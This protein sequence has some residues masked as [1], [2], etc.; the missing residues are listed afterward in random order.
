MKNEP[1]KLTAPTFQIQTIMDLRS[2]TEK[3][4]DGVGMGVFSD[5]S[6]YLTARGLARM[7]GIDHAEIV[8]MS[9]D[10]GAEQFRPR[11][12][13]I[14][15]TLA[16]QGYDKNTI[17]I[18]VEADGVK[19]SAFP[20]EVCMAMLEY[21]AFDAGP[22]R[23]EHALK[24]YRLLARSS[25][26]VFVYTQVGYDPHNNIP[27]AWKQFQDRV[28]LVYNKAPHGYF[29]VFKEVADIIICLIQQNCQVGPEFVPDGSVGSCWG[30]YWTENNLSE[31]HGERVQYEHEYPEDFPQAASNPQPAWAYPDAAL[32]A[33]RKWM[34]EIYLLEKF[35]N[36][37]NNKSKQ[38]MFPPS[39]AELAI[40]AVQIQALQLPKKAGKL[41][42]PVSKDFPAA[43]KTLTTATGKPTES[44]K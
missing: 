23:K 44:G 18:P 13:K 35:P 36:Y 20:E 32:G 2:V 9:N 28:S 16:E 14:A 30:R 3:E 11:G 40:E 8:R 1:K 12:Q 6:T 25:F 38:G 24:N 41:A 15:S 33:F 19:H 29:S 26:R 22:N 39:L 5:G 21:Y 42:P 7:C 37:M 31:L 17:F 10:W 4:I 43:V 34:R 27:L